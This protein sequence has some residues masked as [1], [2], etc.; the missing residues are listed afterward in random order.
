VPPDGESLSGAP[1]G[2]VFLFFLKGLIMQST[3]TVEIPWISGPASGV[4]I[5][6]KKTKQ[7]IDYF[8]CT[9]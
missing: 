9:Q 3:E 8:L 5:C 6:Q 1:S 4:N 7:Q 2:I